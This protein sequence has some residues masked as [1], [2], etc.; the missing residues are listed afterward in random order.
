MSEIDWAPILMALL[1]LINLIISGR[2]HAKL[3]RIG[4][5]FRAGRIL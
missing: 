1:N 4:Y 5:L 2:N 3:R